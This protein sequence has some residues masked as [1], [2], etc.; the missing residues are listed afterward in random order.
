MYYTPSL[1]SREGEGGKFMGIREEARPD[2]YRE[3]LVGENS[4]Y[5]WLILSYTEGLIYQE[6]IDSTSFTVFGIGFPRTLCPLSVIRTL[7]SIRIPPIG[8]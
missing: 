2:S 8:K 1:R 6:Q 4:Y 7:S 5:F 3:G